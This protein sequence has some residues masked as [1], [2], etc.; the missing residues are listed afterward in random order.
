MR[1]PGVASKM[2]PIWNDEFGDWRGL[3]VPTQVPRYEVISGFLNSERVTTVLDVGCGEA[4]LRCSLRHD[5]RYT[6]IEPSALAVDIASKKYAGSICHS[7][8]EAFE[9]PGKQWDRIVF[10]EVL[11]YSKDPIGLL[12]KYAHFLAP[13]GAIVISIFQKPGSISFRKRIAHYFDNRRPM[14]NVHCT[15]MVIRFLAKRKWPIRS[16]QPVAIPGSTNC[17][18]IIVTSPFSVQDSSA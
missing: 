13:G 7:T 17:W 9:A 15:S 12:F 11:Y 16:D 5:I 6:G 8:A 2:T 4:V 14:S 1:V 18:R 10:N 3:M